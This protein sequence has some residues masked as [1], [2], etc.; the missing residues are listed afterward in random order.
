MKQGIAG[1]FINIYVVQLNK[2]VYISVKQK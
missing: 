1:D 2:K